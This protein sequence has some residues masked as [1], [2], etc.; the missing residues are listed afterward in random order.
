MVVLKTKEYCKEKQNGFG[1]KT[2]LSTKKVI[3][4]T[5]KSQAEEKCK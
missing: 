3:N 5:Y 4:V 2:S 1:W